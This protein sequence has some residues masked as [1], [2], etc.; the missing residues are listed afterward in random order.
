MLSKC[1]LPDEQHVKQ[2]LPGYDST[3][4]VNRKLLESVIA[5]GQNRTSESKAS[6]RKSNAATAYD[7]LRVDATLRFY[8]RSGPN[9]MSPKKLQRLM[10]WESRRL[11]RALD[12]LKPRGVFFCE[13]KPG[14]P[15]GVWELELP[16]P[17][18]SVEDILVQFTPVPGIAPFKT[19]NNS[20]TFF[21]LA[22]LYHTMEQDAVDDNNPALRVHAVP[23]RRALGFLPTVRLLSGYSGMPK[24]N[25]AR[26]LP[27]L[28]RAGYF[29][30]ATQQL[31]G[32]MLTW[33][34]GSDP[35]EMLKKQ[36]YDRLRDEPALL[37]HDVAHFEEFR[38]PHP[39]ELDGFVVDAPFPK[40][41]RRGTAE[42]T[43]PAFSEE[44]ATAVDASSEMETD[45]APERTELSDE[46]PCT[47]EEFLLME[48]RKEAQNLILAQALP[49]LHEGVSA[50]HNPTGVH[51]G[52]F[53]NSVTTRTH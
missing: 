5:E 24:S 16:K 23:L 39:Y 19:G 48:M 27:I 10:R 1:I 43:E 22:V 36:E 25:V 40:R 47:A 30:M 38:E 17:G 44:D 41:E 2:D 14:Y 33:R 12:W 8:S 42:V 46:D 32:A 11:Q 15:H 3:A 6:S 13:R 50:A 28:A 26:V 7:A 21:L 9:F 35:F 18:A 29:N 52:L 45:E 20:A 4:W 37:R 53:A 49:H 34:H 31:T 51:T